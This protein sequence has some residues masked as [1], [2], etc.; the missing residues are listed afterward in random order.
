MSPCLPEQPYHAEAHDKFHDEVVCDG[1][2][3]HGEGRDVCT[4]VYACD[5]DPVKKDLGRRR[6]SCVYQK[7]LRT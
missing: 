7:V 6:G 5:E 4:K 2:R 3:E 1:G